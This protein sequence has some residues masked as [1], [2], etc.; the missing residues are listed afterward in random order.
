MCNFLEE[1]IF[2]Y[3]SL[4]QLSKKFLDTLRI[5]ALQLLT[6]TFFAAAISGPQGGGT[7]A[8]K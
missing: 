2:E 7:P 6:H 3:Y 5:H 8:C 1:S 4:C